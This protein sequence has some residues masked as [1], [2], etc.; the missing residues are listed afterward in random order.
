VTTAPPPP[1]AVKIRTAGGTG[2]TQVFT[3]PLQ[4]FTPPTTTVLRTPTPQVFT[5]PRTRVVVTR[6]T[7]AN[8]CL[9]RNAAGQMVNRCQVFTP[10][11]VQRGT[12][13]F[14][15]Q[16]LSFFVILGMGLMLGGGVLRVTGRRRIRYAGEP[17]DA[18]PVERATPV[19]RATPAPS[20]DPM[21][22]RRRL[23]AEAA[24]LGGL[25]TGRR[26]G[27]DWNFPAP[28]AT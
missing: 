28:P 9:V 11:A 10:P 12:L 27:S 2:G 26:G 3:P 6:P 8:G 23:A 21:E 5:P 24:R 15:G 16:Q 19:K 7:V 25:T 14:T 18:L 17:E 4:I 20:S 1:P 13:P 22:V